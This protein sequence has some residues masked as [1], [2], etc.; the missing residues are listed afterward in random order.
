MRASRP[1]PKGCL[2]SIFRCGAG[3]GGRGIRSHRRCGE[4]ARRFK[5]QTFRRV[6]PAPRPLTAARPDSCQKKPAEGLGL[7]GG[8]QV[9]REDTLA[10][11]AITGDICGADLKHRAR[12]AIGLGG[13]AENA[14]STSL[15]VA[16]CRGPWVRAPCL[17]TL[18]KLVCV[19]DPWRPARPR[20]FS[21]SDAEL[22]MRLT[23]GRPKN[24]G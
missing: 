4:S 9:I 16:R 22:G 18:R 19:W 3:S 15:D 24:R 21:G 10:E 13:L 14:D 6:T 17:R 12:D 20:Y 5:P 23:P 8:G 1:I 7:N 11:W 2:C